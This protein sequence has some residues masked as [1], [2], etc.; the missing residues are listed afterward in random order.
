MDLQ[1]LVIASKYS[2]LFQ[3]G[4]KLNWV[5]CLYKPLYG[6][7]NMQFHVFKSGEF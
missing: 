6:N 7:M 3:Y 5:S 1:S 2:I 4:C